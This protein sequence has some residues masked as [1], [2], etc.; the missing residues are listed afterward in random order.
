MDLRVDEIAP[1]LLICGRVEGDTNGNHSYPISHATTSRVRNVLR[2]SRGLK[3]LGKPHHQSGQSIIKA[4]L[5]GVEQIHTLHPEFNIQFE[6]IPGHEDI[7]GND[8]A[9]KAAKSAAT[10]LD[11]S[12]IIP[13]PSLKSSRANA[14]HQMIKITWQTQWSIGKGTACQ[15][16]NMI[17]A[18]NASTGLQIYQRLGNNRRHIA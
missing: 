6:W 5:D 4:I 8:D 3:A 9:D 1:V 18:P 16:R 13:R 14:I 12:R 2:Q 15:L 17:K 7:K 11:V 10:Q